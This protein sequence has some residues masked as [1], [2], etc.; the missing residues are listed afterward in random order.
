MV[1]AVALAESEAAK[2]HSRFT[3][4]PAIVLY[5]ALAKLLLHLLTATRYG[6][7]RDEM[8]Y[9]ACSQHV[10]WG[11]VDHPPMNVFITWFARHA[12]GDSLLGLRLLPAIAGAGLVWM[13][14]QLAREMGGDRFAQSL[15]ALA[16][17]PV[18]IYLIM[19]HWLTMN[20]FEPLLWMGC[21]WC[22]VRGAGDQPRRAS[23]L[24]LVRRA[25]RGWARDQILHRFSC[26]RRTRWSPS[27]S[28]ASFSQERLVV[29]GDAG[30]GRHR[31]AQLRVATAT[32][33]SFPATPAQHPHG[34]SRHRSGPAE[35]PCRP[36]GHHESHPFA[37]VGGRV[38][39]AFF[40]ARRPSVSRARL[41]QCAGSDAVHCPQGQELL[42]CADLPCA[43]C[44][45][46]SGV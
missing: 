10:A 26:V 24:V 41:G 30:G 35:L 27:R 34:Q 15:A 31:A 13:A 22:V 42:C 1:S 43:F 9:V 23:I 46:R 3:S 4:G 25:R 36:G 32:R 17:I 21:L 39:L 2:A 6:I 8:Y 5:L 37:A 14:G 38:A 28:R 19:H 45:R 29:V 7:F 16:V 20:A 33:L 40:R 44:C 12:F 11:Y 18:P